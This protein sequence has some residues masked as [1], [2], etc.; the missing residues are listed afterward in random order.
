MPPV[1]DLQADELGVLRGLPFTSACHW[2]TRLER[3]LEKE[4]VR[5]IDEFQPQTDVVS[6]LT[7]EIGDRAAGRLEV[8]AAKTET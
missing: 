7:I 3:H 8:L 6:L 5:K 1:D 2:I 4:V